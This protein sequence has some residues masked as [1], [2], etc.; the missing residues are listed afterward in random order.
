MLTEPNMNE[1][2]EQFPKVNKTWFSV[3]IKFGEFSNK[4]ENLFLHPMFLSAPSKVSLMPFKIIRNQFSKVNF[5]F[6][7]LD[8]R[9]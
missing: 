9:I 5:L 1:L 6:E 2:Q 4:Y 7:K 3:S 8:F